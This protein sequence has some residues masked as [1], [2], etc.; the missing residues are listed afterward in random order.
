MPSDSY[1]LW[2][3]DL[4]MIE[5]FDLSKSFR[6]V[7]ALDALSFTARDGSVTALLGRNGA[8]KSTTLR[9]L[10]TVMRPDSG[11]A[12]IDG[13]DTVTEMRLVQQRIGALVDTRGL[14]PRL[15]AR[16]HVEYFG[17]LHGLTGSKLYSK[18]DELIE[19]L[20][21]DEFADRRARG[22]SKGQSLKVALARAMIHKPKNLLLDEPTSGLDIAGNRAVRELIRKVR[23]GG[24]CVLF[25][26]HSMTEVNALADQIVII[27]H[28]RTAAAA[29]PDELRS[30]TGTDDLEEV[31]LALTGETADG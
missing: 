3:Y 9:I 1:R 7:R 30:K 14:Y 17:R 13:F 22:F 26:S 5:A 20:D 8:G 21:M 25:C 18:I 6:N 12:R 23:D 10:Y 11:N 27:S 29:S 31:F 15:T 4:V 2:H 19:T 28:G 16:E 24:G